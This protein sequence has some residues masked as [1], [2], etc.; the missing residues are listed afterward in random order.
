MGETT[1]E[2]DIVVCPVCGGKGK[3]PS[4]FYLS[5]MFDGPETPPD[6]NA[7]GNSNLCSKCGGSGE[8]DAEQIIAEIVGYTRQEVREQWVWDEFGEQHVWYDSERAKLLGDNEKDFEK[9]QDKFVRQ[10]KQGFRP[11]LGANARLYKIQFPPDAWNNTD[12]AN[13]AGEAYRAILETRHQVMYADRV[14]LRIESRVTTMVYF[15]LIRGSSETPLAVGSGDC[16]SHAICNAILL[17]ERK[18]KTKCP[19]NMDPNG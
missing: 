17:N 4:S 13:E 5:E 6:L 10:V 19:T 7:P 18:E 14:V 16:Q 11:S 3:V 8:L 1:T 9:E 15:L 12:R 2:A